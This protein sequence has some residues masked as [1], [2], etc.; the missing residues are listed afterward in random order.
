MPLLMMVALPIHPPKL[1][2]QRTQYFQLAVAIA[3]VRKN[4]LT[5]LAR[6]VSKVRIT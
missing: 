6:T 1:K 5:L 3:L 2:N 4:V